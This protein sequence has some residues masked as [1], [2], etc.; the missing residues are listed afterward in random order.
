MARLVLVDFDDNAQ[1]EAFIAKLDNAGHSK[2]RVVGLFARPNRWC[3]CPHPLGY[4]KNEI[5]KGG[6][7]GWWVHVICRRPRMGTHQAK[8]LL[9]HRRHP[10]N[11]ITMVYDSVSMAEVPTKNLKVD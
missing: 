8:N 11:D 5:V 10:H 4:A 9:P 7:Y 3:G 6:A 1:A 2:Y